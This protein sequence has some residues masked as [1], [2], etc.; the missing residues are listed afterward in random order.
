MLEKRVEAGAECSVVLDVG[1]KAWR[2]CIWFMY[3]YANWSFSEGALLLLIWCSAYSK[4]LPSTD[5][6]HSTL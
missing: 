5:S 4:A 6:R 2:K 3:E 1:S